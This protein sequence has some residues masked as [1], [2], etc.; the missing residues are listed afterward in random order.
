MSVKE[1]LT[2]LK[3]QLGSANGMLPNISNS[4]KHR[5]KLT[6]LSVIAQS[7]VSFKNVF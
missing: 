5:K 2:A 7:A 1:K 4:K 3:I 6:A